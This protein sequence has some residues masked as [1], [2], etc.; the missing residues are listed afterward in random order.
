[1]KFIY[2]DLT[3]CDFDAMCDMFASNCE[4][5]DYVYYDGEYVV[6]DITG[7]TSDRRFVLS[8]D[9]VGTELYSN[10]GTMFAVED[11]GSE[12]QVRIISIK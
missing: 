11:Y 6:G 1:M 8:V 3:V 4:V 12:M 10:A 5:V 2:K 9:G 7:I